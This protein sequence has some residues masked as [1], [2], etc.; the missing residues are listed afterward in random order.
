MINIY[1]DSSFKDGRAVA[2]V[3]DDKANAFLISNFFTATDSVTAEVIASM[4]GIQRA[5]TLMKHGNLGEYSI[6]TDCMP[7]AQ[8]LNSTLEL[9]ESS[10]SESTREA[11]CEFLK[12]KNSLVNQ[13]QCKVNVSFVNKRNC[14]IMKVVDMVSYRQLLGKPLYYRQHITFGSF[15]GRPYSVVEKF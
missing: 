15:K 13:F 1:S 11:I 5:A 14:E 8:Y 7:I 6:F 3:F 2:T 9:R 10:F 12:Y 4:Y